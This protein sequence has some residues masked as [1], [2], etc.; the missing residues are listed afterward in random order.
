MSWR[1]FEIEGEF[2]DLSHLGSFVMTV[3]VDS[4]DIE[5]IVSFL[6]HCFTDEKGGFRMPFKHEERYW[7]EERYKASFQLRGLIEK[8]F[9]TSYAIPYLNKKR[10]EQ[11]HYM[12]AYDY[13]IFF[14]INKPEG[15]EDTLKLKIVSAYEL[16][17]WGKGTVP[18]GK[19]KKVSWILSRRNNNQSAL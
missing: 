4:R 12:E 8:N 3:N 18:K 15:T 10:N 13:A 9:I 17:Q 2:R 16:D 14:D 19:P 5:L 7:S 11:Y 6:S 1:G